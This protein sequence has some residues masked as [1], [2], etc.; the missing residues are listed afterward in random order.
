MGARIIDTG[1]E[2]IRGARETE[3]RHESPIAS[4]PDAQSMGVD[5]LPASQVGDGAEQVIELAGAA[6]AEVVGLS[7]VKAIAGTAAIVD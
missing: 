1:R 5:V 3:G 7:V 4:P 2:C 6:W